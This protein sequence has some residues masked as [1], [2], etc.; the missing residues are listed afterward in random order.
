M[1]RLIAIALL[2]CLIA[3]TSAPGQADPE[4]AT[5]A[6]SRRQAMDDPS[7][8]IYDREGVALEVAATLDR[9][10]WASGSPEVRRWAWSEARSV[11]DG[12]SSRNPDHP[13]AGPFAFQA[14][15]YLWA[16]GQSWARHAETG[17]VEAHARAASAFDGAIG[18]LRPIVADLGDSV[19]PLAQNAR[20]RLARALLD[21]ARLD[22]DRLA[23]PA[24]R[25]EALKVV[26]AKPLTEPNLSG[27]AAA[28]RAELLAYADRFDEAR[29]ALAE[30]ARAAMP[31]SASE[32]LAV[33]VPIAAGRKEFSSAR[34]EIDASPLE[35]AEKSRLRLRLSLAERATLEPGA[36]R[37]RVEASAFEIATELKAMSPAEFDGAVRELARAVDEPATPLGPEAWAL[38]AEGAAG[39]GQA[40]RASRLDVIAAAKAEGRGDIASAR[41]WRFRAA[42]RSFAAGRFAR[43]DALFSRIVA[44]PDAGTLRPRAGM[45]RALARGRG[46]AAGEAGLTR[47]DYLA[48]L[49]EQIRDFP[50]D[51]ATGEAR[52]LLGYARLDAGDK[53]EAISIWQSI[54]AAHARWLDAVL[55]VAT[56]RRETLDERRLVDD[57]EALRVLRDEARA[58]V[59]T[60]RRDARD[61]SDRTDLDLEAIR[62]DLAPAASEPRRALEAIDRLRS[63]PLDA[64]QRAQVEAMRIVALAANEKFLEAERVSSDL[65]LPADVTLALAR[66]LDRW[67][68]A[69]RDDRLAR[70]V[71]G[72]E[73]IV[74]D[75]LSATKGL[76]PRDEAQARLRRARGRALSGDF[77]GARAISAPWTDPAAD[78]PGDLADVAD[79]L[80]RVGDH[81]RA[82]AAYRALGRTLKAGS[83][84]WFAARLSHARE[85]LAAGEKRAA[86]QVVEGTALL[87]PEL[88]GPAMRDEFAV[89]RAMIDRP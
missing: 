33:L 10:A 70:R 54:P 88:G 36:E 22:P 52:W 44:D 34:A 30:S 21:R 19:E 64:G 81:P 89:L 87:H 66:D 39:L 73:R 55:A 57:S 8:T 46:V 78:L 15:V 28:L 37:G 31:P 49:A 85:L 67:A 74:A 4:L 65:A 82:L 6:A 40:D 53:A 17:D 42:G 18:R 47:A 76:A 45:L 5:Y 12:F 7:R 25:R 43:A 50:D 51:P 20:F 16:E 48:A 23:S 29:D 11:L 72:I 13:R 14:A 68:V 59:D 84:R 58:A 41:R 26:E 35:P 56:A 2:I 9:S 71:G 38:L 62:L 61:E 86:R 27:F 1:S 63:L 83:P 24:L 69:A 32:R 77:D 3:A 80:A 60:A 75:R 79:L